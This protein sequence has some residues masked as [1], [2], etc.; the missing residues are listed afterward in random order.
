MVQNSH[1]EKEF[2]DRNNVLIITR[3]R[4]YTLNA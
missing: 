1:K 2:I 3:N 4:N